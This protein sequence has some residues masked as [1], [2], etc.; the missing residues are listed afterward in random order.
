MDKKIVSNLKKEFLKLAESSNL[1]TGRYIID[2]NARVKNV[3][4]KD[5]RT[6]QNLSS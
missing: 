2:L 4:I 3:N 1:T 6:N 5:S